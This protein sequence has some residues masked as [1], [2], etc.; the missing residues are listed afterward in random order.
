[1]GFTTIVYVA[2]HL[3]TNSIRA[4]SCRLFANSH[5]NDVSVPQKR[6]GPPIDII[7]QRNDR[8][9]DSSLSHFVRANYESKANKRTPDISDSERSSR[10]TKS[11]TA[12]DLRLGK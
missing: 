3:L 9:T 11:K 8:T 5:R 2:S 12:N 1:M 6:F 4:H 7:V 10:V